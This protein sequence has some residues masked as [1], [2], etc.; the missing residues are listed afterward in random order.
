MFSKQG[1]T[2]AVEGVG[3]RCST[4][5]PS[6]VVSVTACQGKPAVC[7]GL[8]ILF[9]DILICTGTRVLCRGYI[10]PYPG[11]CAEGL[12]E[13]TEVPGAGMDVLQNLQKF[14]VRV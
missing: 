2:C 8:K 14:R 12:T 13:L 7:Q 4:L 9:P 6:S 10:N 11:Y 3:P 5:N 1:K